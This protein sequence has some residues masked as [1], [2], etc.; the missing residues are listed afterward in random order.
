[1]YALK[2][3][4]MAYFVFPVLR[5]LATIQVLTW[6]RHPPTEKQAKYARE[7]LRRAKADQMIAAQ[8]QRQNEIWFLEIEEAYQSACKKGRGPTHKAALKQYKEAYKVIN[9]SEENLV[10]AD[11]KLQRTAF[12]YESVMVGAGE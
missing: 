1:M 7:E 8:I 11:E 4:W 9:L 12:I 2:G 5:C 3:I 10:V 6:Y